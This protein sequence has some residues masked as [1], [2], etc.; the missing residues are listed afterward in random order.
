MHGARAAR[1]VALL[2][3]FVVFSASA[4]EIDSRGTYNGFF[5]SRQHPGLWGLMTFKIGDVNNHRAMGM[6]T[7][8]IGGAV[9]VPFPVDLTV[10]TS[11]EFTGNGRG[12]GGKVQFHG[13]IMFLDGGAAVADATYFLMPSEV[14][15]PEPD[16]GTATVIRN[17]VVGPDR[18]LPLIGGIW[19]G[20]ATSSI[21]GS[22]S[23]FHLDVTQT[24]TEGRPGTMFFGKEVIDPNMPFIFQGSINGDGRFVVAG[25]SFTND[26]FI[27]IGSYQQPPDPGKPATAMANY[28]LMFGNGFTD[29][30]TFD[31]M[32]RGIPPDPCKPI[33]GQ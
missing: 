24:C 15:P 26:R 1:T 22:Q 27:V 13:Q 7:M 33:S 30:G 20:L 28:T 10:S 12:P 31:M 19:D 2:G 9:E 32:Q 21:D 5:Q 3:F 11:G 16:R 4:R 17:F 8:L 29:R 6:V 14:Q 23:T 25:W 18:Q